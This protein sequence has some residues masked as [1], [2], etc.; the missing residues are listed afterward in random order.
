M[1]VYVFQQIMHRFDRLEKKMA[2]ITTDIQALTDVVSGVVA[3]VA[4]V[5][6][7]LKAAPNITP[8]QVATFEAQIAALQKAKADLDAAITPPA[9]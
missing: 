5:L 7:L 9:A 8:D 1:D 2:D 6:T 4:Q 3:D